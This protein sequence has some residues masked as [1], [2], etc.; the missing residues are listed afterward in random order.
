MNRGKR[1][2]KRTPIYFL[3]ECILLRAHKFYA[4]ADKMRRFSLEPL[5]S[6]F[7]TNNE[8][9]L[10]RTLDNSSRLLPS[11]SFLETLL[12]FHFF[13]KLEN[14]I[15]LC[16]NNGWNSM[17]KN[18]EAIFKSPSL[19]RNISVIHLELLL[20]TKSNFDYVC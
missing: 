4:Y 16:R 2:P 15:L 14:I 11:K 19:S 9:E 20:Y 18:L 8:S 10:W 5:H 17:V 7:H 12:Y 1:M 6:F 3:K 13:S